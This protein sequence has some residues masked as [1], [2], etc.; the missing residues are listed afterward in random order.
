LY[1]SSLW[2][3][4]L[5]LLFVDFLCL[6]HVCVLPFPAN[7]SSY[8]LFVSCLPQGAPLDT[9]VHLSHVT[10]LQ[11]SLCPALTLGSWRR[12]FGAGLKKLA[13]QIQGVLP[14]V[15]LLSR[16]SA[17]SGGIGSDLQVRYAVQHWVHELHSSLQTMPAAQ[18][19]GADLPR[20]SRPSCPGVPACCAP[21][22]T[23]TS[24]A[25]PATPS[26]ICAGLPGVCAGAAGEGAGGFQRGCVRVGTKARQGSAASSCKI[27]IFCMQMHSRLTRCCACMAL[28]ASAGDTS[29]QPF[30]DGVGA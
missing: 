13:R 26:P 29:Y 1:E 9:S 14:V 8:S 24:A 23:Q 10:E 5:F 28:P 18:R 16:L 2:L 21:K 3:D 20:N 6:L 4:S 7:I 12:G 30:N 17:P 15:G 22:W 11:N 25:S 27:T 19:A